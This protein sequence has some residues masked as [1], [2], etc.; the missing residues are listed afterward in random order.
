MNGIPKVVEGDSSGFIK[1]TNKPVKNKVERISSFKKKC[2]NHFTFKILA[3][4][5]SPA[6]INHEVIVRKST[7]RLNAGKTSSVAG[8]LPG[9]PARFALPQS[10][11]AAFSNKI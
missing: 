10:V 2:Y 11:S 7:S 3:A 1:K 5:L 9:D 4:C 8:K 6:I